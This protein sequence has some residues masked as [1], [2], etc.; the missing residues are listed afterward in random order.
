MCLRSFLVRVPSAYVDIGE[1]FQ[2]VNQR[3]EDYE[4]RL[5]AP[6][7]VAPVGHDELLAWA[8]QGNSTLDKYIRQLWLGIRDCPGIYATNTL[9]PRRLR[10]NVFQIGNNR[11]FMTIIDG[12]CNG[13]FIGS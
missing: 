3:L 13:M 7:P 8:H 6:M 2:P 12:V 11:N 10:E 9:D 4:A 1:K 5:A